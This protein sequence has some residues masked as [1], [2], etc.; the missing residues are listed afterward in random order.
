[1]LESFQT[2]RKERQ[3]LPLILRSIGVNHKQENINR[4]KGISFH[5]WFYCSRGQGELTVNGR[6]TIITP[7]SAF[8]IQA[9][10]AHKY[11]GSNW[12]LHFFGFEGSICS[13][14]LKTLN[15][16]ESGVFHMS[17]PEQFYSQLNSLAL[18]TRRTISYEK[19]YYSELLYSI[20]I[21]L[22]L[23]ISRVSDQSASQNNPTVSLIISYLEEHYFE[24]VSLTDLSDALEKTPE[25]LCALFKQSLHLTII[26]ELTNIRIAHAR[27][28]LV[29]YPEKKASEIGYLCG[30]QSPSYFG[31][32]FKKKCGVSPA[33]YRLN[34]L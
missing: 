11:S 22:S 7:G 21:N 20:L 34:K 6:R 8:F 15:M 18:A 9:H 14:L 16:T 30:F 19:Y 32:V 17:D 31:K 1:M 25:Y 26:E 3:K 33:E 12:I 29:E 28:M 13:S 2:T 10:D 5:Q 4:P 24:N 27:N 23:Q